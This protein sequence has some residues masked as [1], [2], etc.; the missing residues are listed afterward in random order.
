MLTVISRIV[1]YGFANFWRNGWP[2]AATVAIMVLALLVFIGLILFNVVTGQA[3]ASVEN[4]IDVSVYFKTNTPEDEILNV[5]Q[6]LE[7]L[8]EVK[9][10]VYVSSDEA[11]AIFQERHAND[12]LG[13][14]VEEVTGNPFVASLNI[15]AN[16]PDQYATI[17]QYLST[18]NLSQYFDKVSYFENQEVIDRLVAIINNVNRGGFVLT[19][20]LILVAGLVV[21]NSIGL[22]IYSSREEIGI[23]RAVGASNALVRGPFM[24]EGVIAGVLAAIISIL[25]AAPLTYFVS[26]YFAAF[27]PGLDIF[28]YFYSHIPSLLGYQLLFGILVGAFSSTIAVRRYLRN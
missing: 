17:A 14:A 22:V 21:F 5:K 12:P 24:V 19:V 23:M 18:P 28:Q 11:L 25:I 2:S 6:S 13:Q 8:R 9:S 1:H 15:Q 3:M 26:P 20:I 27:I 4:K 16:S 10:V 7:S